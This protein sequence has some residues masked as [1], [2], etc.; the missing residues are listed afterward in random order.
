VTSTGSW[1]L[2]LFIVR[3]DPVPLVQRAVVAGQPG[4]GFRQTLS[5]LAPTEAL[6]HQ[7]NGETNREHPEELSDKPAQTVKEKR[8]DYPS[9]KDQHDRHEEQLPWCRR[10]RVGHFIAKRLLG[11]FFAKPS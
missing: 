5:G 9:A 8:E 10:A 1:N 6:Y 4:A 11:S 7:P 2:Q 3:R